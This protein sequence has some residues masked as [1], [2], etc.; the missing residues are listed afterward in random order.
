MVPL[1]KE[2]KMNFEKL[3]EISLDLLSFI[4]K[5]KLVYLYTRALS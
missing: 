4:V 2:N 3:V 1:I 5:H